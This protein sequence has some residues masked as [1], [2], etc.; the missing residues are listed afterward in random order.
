MSENKIERFRFSYNYGDY[1][2]AETFETSLEFKYCTP[3]HISDVIEK[4]G[5]FLRGCGFC[6]DGVDEETAADGGAWG[7]GGIE[8]G[9]GDHG[10]ADGCAGIED[11]VGGVGEFDAMGVAAGAGVGVGFADDGDDL[12]AVGAEVFG[13]FDGDDIAAAG[14]DDEGGVD[15]GEDEVAEDAGG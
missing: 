11:E 4:F 13:H 8:A 14:G 6:F 2:D 15:W 7:D 5:Q 10:V 9:D 12:D 1:D 3:A